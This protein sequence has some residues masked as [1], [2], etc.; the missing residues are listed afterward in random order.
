MAA[1][2][3]SLSAPLVFDISP[4]MESSSLSRRSSSRVWE[5]VV[6]PGAAALL[7]R[8]AL[9]RELSAVKP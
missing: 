6:V 2:G 4:T 1:R 5:A 9:S 3:T 7:L 8:A